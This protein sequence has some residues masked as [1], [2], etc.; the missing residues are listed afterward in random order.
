MHGDALT[1]PGTLIVPA[2][3]TGDHAIDVVVDP[4]IG[5]V[6]PSA[7][8]DD[9]IRI[10]AQPRDIDLAIAFEIACQVGKR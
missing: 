1:L 6:D 3:G 10:G 2:C 7:G 9:K 8:T 4:E 5:R